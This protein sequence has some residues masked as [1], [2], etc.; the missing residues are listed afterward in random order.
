M[1]P[2]KSDGRR[3]SINLERTRQQ[4]QDLDQLL[5]QMLA[6]PMDNAAPGEPEM[7]SVAE[8]PHR[9]A[10]FTIVASPATADVPKQ[11]TPTEPVVELR[12]YAPPRLAGEHPAEQPIAPP[13]ADQIT[14]KDG[15]TLPQPPEPQATPAMEAAHEPGAPGKSTIPSAVAAILTPVDDSE[16][17]T[18]AKES[19]FT[20]PLTSATAETPGAG[21]SSPA[22]KDADIHKFDLRG[23]ADYDLTPDHGWEALSAS[24]SPAGSPPYQAL[25]GANRLFD[26]FL[27]AFGPVGRLLLS[28]RGRDILGWTGVILLVTAAAIALVGWL[29]WPL[30][31]ELLK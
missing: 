22:G 25:A 16:T 4:L 7:P 30:S 3:P 26:R 15:P 1:T 18:D 9:P 21:D 14:G 5:K 10:T 28:H 19:A 24:E 11:A 29:S 31:R 20:A 27:H 17:E 23:P 8:T 13:V 12:V 2:A 6:L